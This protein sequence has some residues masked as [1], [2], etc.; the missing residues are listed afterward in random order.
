VKAPFCQED[1]PALGNEVRLD[2]FVVSPH[3]AQA[4]RRNRCARRNL[5]GRGERIAPYISDGRL[6]QNSHW[7]NLRHIVHSRTDEVAPGMTVVLYPARVEI[8]PPGAGKKMHMT[9]WTGTLDN[10]FALYRL[11]GRFFCLCR[12]C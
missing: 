12:N 2:G 11:P 5:L 7:Q 1:E 9:E 8:A 4:D 6:P 10:E 3:H